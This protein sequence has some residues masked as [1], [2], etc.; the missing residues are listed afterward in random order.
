MPA[1]DLAQTSQL[2]EINSERF[3]PAIQVAGNEPVY[4]KTVTDQ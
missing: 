2:H 4:K 3:A 1:S